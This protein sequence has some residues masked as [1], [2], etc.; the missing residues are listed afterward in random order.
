MKALVLRLLALLAV[1]LVQLSVTIVIVASF[2]V[3]PWYFIALIP[4]G[5]GL[6]LLGVYSVYKYAQEDDSKPLTS[7]RRKE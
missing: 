2:N 6:F 1:W 7:Y 3:S 4:S 5:V